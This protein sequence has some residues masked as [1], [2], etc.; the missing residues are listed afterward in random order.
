MNKEYCITAMSVL[1]NYFQVSQYNDKHLYYKIIHSF[2]QFQSCIY[3]F[4]IQNSLLDFPFNQS[5]IE[6][7]Y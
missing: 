5:R 6:H 2:A 1:S 3:F 4:M 7:F